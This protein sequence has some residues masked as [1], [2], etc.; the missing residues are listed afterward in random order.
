MTKSTRPGWPTKEQIARALC[1][2]RNTGQCAALCLRHS[3]LFTGKG[4]CP[5]A[6]VIFGDDAV[7][8]LALFA[9]AEKTEWPDKCHP[10]HTT[11]ISLDASSYDEICITTP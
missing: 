11:R 3:S 6:L 4:Q 8:I 10:S 7:A 1:K 2:R 9:S 5:E